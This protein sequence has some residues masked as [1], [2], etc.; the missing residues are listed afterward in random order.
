M[1][2]SHISYV[3]FERPIPFAVPFGRGKKRCQG[4]GIPDTHSYF[5]IGKSVRWWICSG[6]AASDVW[7]EGWMARGAWECMGC[8]RE[9][10]DEVLCPDCSKGKR[11]SA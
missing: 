1:T 9:I 11:V 10:V 2:T 8:Q 4:H 7:R 5:V 6:C 3:P